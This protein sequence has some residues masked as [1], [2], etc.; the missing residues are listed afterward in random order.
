MTRGPVLVVAAHPDDE[1]LGCGGTMATLTTAGSEVHVLILGTGVAA[2]D[3]PVDLVPAAIEA[4]QDSAL[5]AGRVLGAATVT[6]RDLPDNRFDTEALLDVIKLVEAAVCSLRPSVVYTHHP[7]CLNVDHRVTYEAVLTATRPVGDCPVRAL[8][9]FEVPSSTDW[10]FGTL[11][12]FRPNVFVSIGSA[13]LAAK[14]A[15]M[16]AYSSEMRPYPHPRSMEAL[17]AT[18]RRW[19]S[20]AGVEAAEAFELIR[21]VWR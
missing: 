14:L 20:V 13:G 8:Y 5:A 3:M 15:A 21:E 19:G 2:R 7:G 12:T 17:T 16:E 6:V 18:A 10:A 1:V 9:A 4:L 11:A